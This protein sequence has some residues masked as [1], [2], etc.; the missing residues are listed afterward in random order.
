MSRV[1]LHIK[2]HLRVFYMTCFK[3]GVPPFSTCSW[4]LLSSIGCVVTCTPFVGLITNFLVKTSQGGISK[5]ITCSLFFKI[6]K[7]SHIVISL[8]PVIF[9]NN[10][11]T[12]FNLW[13]LIKWCVVTAD[14]SKCLYFMFLKCSLIQVFKFLLHYLIPVYIVNFNLKIFNLGARRG[15]DV[16]FLIARLY[17]TCLD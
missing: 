13:P 10:F 3:G 11:G 15:G 14:F 6:N 2:H 5:F 1:S 8:L 7:F 9:F 4:L 17:I 16:H 12:G